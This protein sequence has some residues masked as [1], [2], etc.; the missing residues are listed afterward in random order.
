M[1]LKEFYNERHRTHHLES[2]VHVIPYLTYRVFLSIHLSVHLIFWCISKWTFD[3]HMLL[4]KYVHMLLNIFLCLSHHIQ[5]AYKWLIS[6]TMCGFMDSSALLCWRNMQ[7]ILAHIKFIT[8]LLEL[9]KTWRKSGG[10]DLPTFCL[11][12]PVP[13]SYLVFG[14]WYNFKFWIK[15]I[16][17]SQ[18]SFLFI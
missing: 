9:M 16:D 15:S 6:S 13:S 11:Y 8:Q 5:T 10:K 4:P 1:K 2:A 18:I 3:L 7:F 14:S 12:I 17:R